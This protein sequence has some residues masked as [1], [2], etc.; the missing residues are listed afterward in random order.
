MWDPQA[1]TNYHTH[2][3]THS[4]HY[5][6]QWISVLNTIITARKRSLGQG[7]IFSSTCQKFCSQGEG[8]CHSVSWDTT[9]PPGADPQDQAPTPPQ[10]GTPLEQTPPSG[11]APP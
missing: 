11:Q 6:L 4:V 9:Q 2:S 1:S 7:N 8:V 3:L 10:P 5:T